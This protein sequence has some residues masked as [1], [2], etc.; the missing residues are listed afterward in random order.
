[1]TNKKIKKYL[2]SFQ[3]RTGR[4]PFRD[5]HVTKKLPKIMKTACC[6]CGDIGDIKIYLGESKNKGLYFL[7]MEKKLNGDEGEGE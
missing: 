6:F 1:M 4:H 2:F 3:T 7:S 5:V